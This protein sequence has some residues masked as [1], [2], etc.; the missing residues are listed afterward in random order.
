MQARTARG[1]PLTPRRACAARE[2]PTT[3]AMEQPS[4]NRQKAGIN[5]PTL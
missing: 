5:I 1:M 3:Q 2:K 4:F